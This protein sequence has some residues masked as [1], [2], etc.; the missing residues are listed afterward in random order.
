VIREEKEGQIVATLR[1]KDTRQIAASKE[2]VRQWHK[3][4]GVHFAHQI[5][6]LMRHYQL[7]EQVTEEKQG[8]GGS[9]SL[10]KDERVQ[11]A[12]RAHLS[13]IPKGKVTPKGF[14]HALNEQILPLLRFALKA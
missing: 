1:I 5:L 7:F 4:T 2:I 8:I 14:H 12:A 13:T 10:L 6:F 11:A 3:G 9:H